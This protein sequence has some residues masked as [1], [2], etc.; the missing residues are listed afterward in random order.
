MT[1]T[2]HR[3]L[4]ACGL[5]ACFA[6]AAIAQQNTE[7]GGSTLKG[8]T[9]GDPNDARAAA[10]ASNPSGGAALKAQTK[11]PTGKKVVPPAAGRQ[12]Q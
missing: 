6:T 4:L 9:R 12:P 5:A 7:T 3:V 1:S 10:A 8:T 2:G 11:G